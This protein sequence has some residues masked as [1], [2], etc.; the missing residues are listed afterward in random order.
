MARHGFPFGAYSRPMF[1]VLFFAWAAICWPA[2]AFAQDSSPPEKASRTVRVLTIGNSFAQNACIYLRQ[3]GN[4]DGVQIIVGTANLG[5]CTLQKHAMLAEQSAKTP[6]LKPYKDQ[7]TLD[8]KKFNLQDYLQAE[9]WDYVTVQQMSALSYKPESYHPYLE[10]IVATIKQYAPQAKILVHETWAYH[11]DFPLLKQEDI[12]QRQM[13]DRL[14]AAYADVGKQLNAAIIPVGTAF[15]LSR[16]ADGKKQLVTKDF[17]HANAKGCY[18]AGLVWYEALTGNDARETSYIPQ[19]ITAGDAV[20][21]RDI[22][23]KAM[24][25]QAMQTPVTKVPAKKAPAKKVP[26]KKAPAQNAQAK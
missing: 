3:I 1:S 18:L 24:Q 17:K 15:Q 14:H 20:F 19:G 2:D 5:G 21:F 8:G 16:A 13:F 26:A 22:A 23:H 11:P 6:E 9:K 12:T 4:S 25:K 10:Q 7:R